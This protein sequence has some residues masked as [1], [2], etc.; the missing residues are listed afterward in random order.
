MFREHSGSAETSQERPGIIWQKII[1]GVW[2]KATVALPR[3]AQA[4]GAALLQI[5]QE[6]TFSKTL[7]LNECRKITLDLRQ[8]SH[9][10]AAIGYI[11]GDPEQGSGG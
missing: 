10:F 1:F 5:L 3:K 11:L 8:K 9:S 2:K 4:A 6:Q 7:S